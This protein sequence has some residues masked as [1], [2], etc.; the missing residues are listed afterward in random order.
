LRANRAASNIVIL[1]SMRRPSVTLLAVRSMVNG[2][3]PS[4]SA[5]T[6]RR[7][8]CWRSIRPRSAVGS[9]RVLP[10]ITSV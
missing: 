2:L 3:A 5:N 6:A 8:F 1:S 9:I 4:T 7:N 10:L